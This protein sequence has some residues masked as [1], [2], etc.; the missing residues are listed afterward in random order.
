MSEKSSDVGTRPTAR[1]GEKDVE[2]DVELRSAVKN[3]D[4]ALA[5]EPLDPQIMQLERS[6]H[7][8]EAADKIDEDLASLGSEESE[9]AARLR[10]ERLRLNRMRK[11]FRLT[12]DDVLDGMQKALGGTSRAASSL[13][14]DLMERRLVDWREIDGERRFLPRYFETLQRH[15]REVPG[16]GNDVDPDED[17]LVE[18]LVTMREQGSIARRITLRASISSNS[19]VGADEMVR[20]WLPLP[21]SCAEQHD[22]EV[23]YESTPG[24][25]VSSVDAPQRTIFWEGKGSD[26]DLGD[27]RVG[28]SVLYRYTIEMPY[29]ALY[30]ASG[31]AS[32]GERDVVSGYDDPTSAP[33]DLAHHLEEQAPHVVFTPF[34]RALA[35]KIVGEK[36]DSIDKA[37]AIYD[38]ITRNVKYR[39]QPAYAALESIA[40]RTARSL[41][42]DCGCMSLLFIALCRIAGVPARWQ[43]GLYVRPSGAVL[44][45]ARAHDWAQFYAGPEYGWRWVDCSFGS[46]A[47][48]AGDELKRTHYFGNL[49][50]LRMIA[51]TDFFAPLAPPDDA[52]R[53]DPFDNQLGE[54]SVGGFGL[55]RY[56]MTRGV[57]VVDFERA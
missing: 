45:G 13:L 42:G 40:E 28:L 37:R 54:M 49:D 11:E 32:R 26:F 15:A 22:V 2:R 14:D 19:P 12:R 23:F 17:R 33:A 27:G 4:Y 10:V 24:G 31:A 52:L 38:Y 3:S 35:R 25:L 21:V 46:T 20:A 16:L 44:G 48:R 29:V 53:D 43:S 39:Y 55:D 51:T 5:S 47:L 9:Q 7:T 6:G 41:T 18:M 57:E 36:Q 50:P 56:E 30:G 1:S 8:K 34:L